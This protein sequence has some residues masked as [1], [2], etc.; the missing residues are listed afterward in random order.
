M[1]TATELMN[2]V[3]LVSPQSKEREEII[4]SLTAQMAASIL[5]SGVSLDDTVAVTLVLSDDGWMPLWIENLMP[6][7]IALAR[8]ALTIAEVMDVDIS[9]REIRH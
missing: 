3:T 5:R 9:D 6:R 7:A 1:T 8:R 2:G 4:A